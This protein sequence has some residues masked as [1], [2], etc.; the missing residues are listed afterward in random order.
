M[1]NYVRSYIVRLIEMSQT[2]N[3]PSVSIVIPVFNEAAGLAACLDS[4]AAQTVRANQII[5]VDNNSTDDTA[6]IAGRYRFV[7][8]LHERRQGTV[9]ARNHGFNAASS[10][11]IGRID[12]DVMLAPDWVARL[13]QDFASREIAGVTG[14][15]ETDALL[16]TSRLRTR[17]WSR[18][19][20][21]LSNAFFHVPVMQGGNMAITASAWRSI[22][23]FTCPDS[24][25]VHEDQDLSI[26]LAAHG[27]RVYQDPHLL[28]ALPRGGQSHHDWLKLTEYIRRRYSTRSYHDER[29]TLQ[30]PKAVL[31]SGWKITVIAS[32]MFVPFIVFASTSLL[33][34]QFKKLHLML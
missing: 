15:I 6:T 28:A 17:L 33:L 27:Y 4:I 26:V 30:N 12:G 11:I 2:S 21:A 7:T 29:R 5:V 22:S 32:I 1:V 8:I 34:N 31:L 19:Y 13:Q 23:R 16:G 18:V 14:L 9:A 3:Q 25:V 20:L 24:Y 10:E